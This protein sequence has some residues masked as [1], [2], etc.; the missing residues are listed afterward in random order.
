MKKFFRWLKYLL[1]LVIIFLFKKSKASEFAYTYYLNPEEA[2]RRDDFLQGAKRPDWNEDDCLSAKTFACDLLQAKEL[3]EANS[4]P[5]FYFHL[6][7]DT[8]IL[9]AAAT[10][11]SLS[12]KLNNEKARRGI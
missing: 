8:D 6:L 2:A 10:I 9:S 11:D 1:P 12:R 5:I 3:T 4:L 7:H